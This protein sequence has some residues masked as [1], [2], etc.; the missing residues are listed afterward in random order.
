MG[1]VLQ[2]DVVNLHFLLELNG[3]KVHL[4]GINSGCS[5][6]ENILIFTVEIEF[7]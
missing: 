1:Y 2:S 6:G 3:M 5:T 4:C 7:L